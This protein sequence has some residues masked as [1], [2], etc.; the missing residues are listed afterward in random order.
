MTKKYYSISLLQKRLL[1]F[2][3]LITFL[4]SCLI[5]RLSYVQ[6]INGNWLQAK[7][8]DQW[9]RDVPLKAKRGTIYDRNDNPIAI[10]S[11][12]YDIYVRSKNVSNPVKCASELSSILGIEFDKVYQKV[13]NKLVSESLIASKVSKE[14]INEIK[15]QKLEGVVMS[16]N[17]QRQYPFGNLFTQVLGFTTSDGIGQSGLEAFYDEFLQG[18]NGTLLSQGDVQGRELKGTIDYYL[19][20][21]AGMNLETTLDSKIQMLLEEQLVKCLIEQKAKTVTGIVMNPNTGEIYA[22]GSTPSFNLNQVPRDNVS[23]MLKIAKNMAVVDIYE[24]GSTFKILTSAISLNE[25]VVTTSDPFYDPGYRIVDGEKIK[26]WK[27]VGHG[28][29]TFTDGFCNSCNAV[30]IDLALRLGVD[31]FYNALRT[32]GIGQKTDI[33]FMGEASGIMRNSAEVKKVDLARIGFGQAI[34]VTPIQLITA[35]SST[36]NGGHLMKPYLVKKITSAENKLIKVTEPTKIRDTISGEVSATI[37]MFLEEAVS[38]PLGKYTFLPNYCVGGKTGTTQKYVDGMIKSSYIASFFGTFPADKPDY[39]ILFI[40]DEPTASSYY[41]SIVASPYAKEVIKGIIEYK[42][43]K[44]VTNHIETM[45]VEMPNCVGLSLAQAVEM[46]I[47]CGLAYELVGDGG[48]VI[49]QFPLEKTLI[50]K[51]QTIQLST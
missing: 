32:F 22:M 37:R 31:K 44:P 25:G 14:L 4:F 12:T 46:I 19:P 10:S 13:S 6:L 21:T 38:R 51:G 28:A 49:S 35:L 24:P 27:Y 7:A 45:Q 39:V 47:D 15:Q 8:M 20:S 18:V 36:V 3:L 50:N 33:D 43:Y 11:Q 2:V 30:F 26:C 16:E 1:V 34:A 23:E 42:N 17:Y 48:T 29:Q 41:G 9:T 40:A 5:L